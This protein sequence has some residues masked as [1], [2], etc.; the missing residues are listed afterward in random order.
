VTASLTPVIALHFGWTASFL[1]AACLCLLGA[2]ACQWTPAAASL[3]TRLRFE[4]KKNN[5]RFLA[6]RPWPSE[7]VCEGAFLYS[8]FF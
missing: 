3:E 7:G 8:W 6:F 5:E 4:R 2:L 1:V